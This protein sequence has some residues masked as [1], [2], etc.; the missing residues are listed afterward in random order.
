[1]RQSEMLRV[2]ELA[3]QWHLSRGSVYRAIRRGQIPAVK[4]GGILLIPRAR[5]DELAGS[6][7]GKGETT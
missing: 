6:H 2:S 1:M 4:I 3:K 5:L 7:R